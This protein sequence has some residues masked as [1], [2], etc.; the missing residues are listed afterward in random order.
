MLKWI[1]KEREKSAADRQAERYDVAVRVKSRELPGYRALTDDISAT[2]LQLET[3]GPL[4]KG[5]VLLLELEFDREEL[6]DFSCPAEVMWARDDDNRRQFRAG[7]AFRPNTDK[8][9]TDL[10]RMGAVLESRS[11]ADIQDLLAEANRLD[12]TRQDFYSRKDGGPAVLAAASATKPSRPATPVEAGQSAPA[13]PP[14][15]PGVLVPLEI[16][17]QGYVWDENRGL[18]IYYLDAGQRHQL[19]F[20]DCQLCHDH[21]CAFYVRIVAFYATTQSDKIRE[22]Q[23]LRGNMAWRHYRFLA[24]GGQPVLDI[25][26]QP[27]QAL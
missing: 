9:R 2:G 24:T 19:L 4:V 26:A 12:A 13:R 11:E 10:A 8:Q 3:E 16:D 21:G 1:W 14:S 27:C 6:P 22:L 15:H 25:V 17:I 23:A 7:L 20:P 5:Q 18:T